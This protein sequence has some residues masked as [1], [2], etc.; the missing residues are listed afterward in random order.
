M[1]W[2]DTAL[3]FVKRM[4]K[5][6][7]V[8]KTREYRFVWPYNLQQMR[9]MVEHGQIDKRDVAGE[10]TRHAQEVPISFMR[11]QIESLFIN[12]VSARVG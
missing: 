12:R 1:Y 9:A 7:R 4:P 6:D 8:I 10:L 2:D 11:Q 3:V 5:F